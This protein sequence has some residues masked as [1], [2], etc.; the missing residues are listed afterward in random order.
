MDQQTELGCEALKLNN[1]LAKTD[2][3]QNAALAQQLDS[4]VALVSL[5]EPTFPCPRH[6]G[7]RSIPLHDD[8]EDP[9]L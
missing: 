4:L 1:Q 9:E 7:V 8:E 3:R 2:A 5:R 6:R